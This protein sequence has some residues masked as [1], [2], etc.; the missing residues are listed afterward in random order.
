MNGALTIGENI[1]DLGGACVA[2]EAYQMSL[3]GREAPVIDGFSGVQRFFIG[4]AQN[5]NG[6]LRP[7]EIRRRIATDPHSPEEFRA[8]QILKNITEFYEAFDIQEGDPLWIPELERVR[9]W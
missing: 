4:Y 9:I 3:Q 7:E 1:G 5:W 6:K 8:N 2:L